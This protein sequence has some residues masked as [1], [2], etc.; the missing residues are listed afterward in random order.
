[1]LE[2]IK[3][4]AE[5]SKSRN[6]KRGTLTQSN[7]IKLEQGSNKSKSPAIGSKMEEIAAHY[8]PKEK[9]ALAELAITKSVWMRTAQFLIKHNAFAVRNNRVAKNT[10]LFVKLVHL[11][12]VCLLK[13][14]E[15]CM[16]KELLSATGGP[17]CQYNILL[18]RIKLA[19]N[20][21]DDAEKYC[22]EALQFDYMVKEEEEEEKKRQSYFI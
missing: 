19:K 13:W 17:S 10:F 8:S 18:T 1:M 15:K 5:A 21:L 7:R 11:I 6:S 20:E 22:V 14:A 2:E 4:H 16:A 12:I 9:L 3:F